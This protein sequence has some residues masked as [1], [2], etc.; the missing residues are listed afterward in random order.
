MA[1]AAPKTAPRTLI[2]GEGL[3]EDARLQATERGS[4]V[5]L[6]PTD[7]KP[8]TIV[9]PTADGKS[10]AWQLQGDFRPKTVQAGAL[11]DAITST[12]HTD[13]LDNFTAMEVTLKSR[14]HGFP[15]EALAYDITP[16]GMHYLLIHYDVPKI[17]ADSY[18]VKV[19]G[20]IKTPLLLDL[21]HLRAR[22]QM[23]QPVTMECGGAGRIHQKHRL[24]QHVP[25]ND[26]AIG[27]AL[28]TGCSLADILREAGPLEGVV[29]VIFTGRDKGIEAGKV[30]MFQ[31]S[32]TLKQAMAPEVMLVYAMNGQPLLPQH[33]A[34]LRL[35][36]PGWLGMTNVKWL[37][38]I[39]LSTTDFKGHQMIAYSRAKNA[40]D[41][42]RVPLTDMRAR[43]L[44]LPP[45]IPHFFTRYRYVELDQVIT[46]TG[47]AWAGHA[48]IRSVE[49]TVDGGQVWQRAEL[50]APLGDFAWAPWTFPWR[51]TKLGP[52]Q[53]RVRCTDSNGKT[54]SDAD[55]SADN[56]Y[57]MDI[58]KPQ[59]VD[60][61]VVEAGKLRPGEA[62]EV[63]RVGHCSF[64]C[65]CLLVV[66]PKADCDNPYARVMLA[67]ADAGSGDVSIAVIGSDFCARIAAPTDVVQPSTLF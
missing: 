65:S 4:V 61:V 59:Y 47:R 29:S 60:V 66:C 55:E 50:G 48:S 17:D 45:G 53:L 36:V 28:W 12:A 18:A 63:R 9:Y 38:S 62:I 33:G 52:V 35:I 26:E 34:P 11:V 16:T 23:T 24:W 3:H 20:A 40:S 6:P 27:T 56:F 37:N 41:E 7:G 58:N 2:K 5:V 13:R 57:A 15:M 1:S 31:R 22:P 44:M 19:H 51:P 64:L 32:L 10:R 39:E 30:Q 67:F 8:A 54:Q 43:A 42:K 21:A 25:W 14:C 46:L 49:V